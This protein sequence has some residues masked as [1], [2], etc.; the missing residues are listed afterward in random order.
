VL[1][2][3]DDPGGDHQGGQRR[4]PHPGQEG[5]AGEPDVTEHDEV[6]EVRAGEEQGAGVGQQQ[7]PVEEGGFASAPTPGGVDQ[8]RGEEGHRGVQVQHGRDHADH[9]RGPGEEADA[10]RRDPPQVVAGG[11]KEAVVVGDQADQQQSGHQYE[12]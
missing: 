10:A 6:G 11:G 8:Y 3:G 4:S 2:D 5:G 7:A 9:H 12:R 1:A